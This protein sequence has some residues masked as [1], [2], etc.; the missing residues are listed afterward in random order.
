M[1]QIVAKTAPGTWI[2]P[3][4]VFSHTGSSTT[5]YVTAALDWLLSHAFESPR[6]VAAN[7]SFAINETTKETDYCPGNV[8]ADRLEALIVNGIVPVIATG[9]VG[10]VDGVSAPS[11]VEGVLAIG[12]TTD[13]YVGSRSYLNPTHC[14]DPA[15]SADQV[16]CFSNSHPTMLSVFAPGVDIGSSVPLNSQ[17]TS[18]SVLKNSGTSAAAAHVSGAVAIL[19]GNDAFGGSKSAQ[20]MISLIENNGFL[21]IDRRAA[22]IQKPRLDITRVLHV[23]E[24]LYLTPDGST[25]RPG[26]TLQLSASAYDLFSSEVTNPAVA[27]TSSNSGVARVDSK[28]LVTAVTDGTATIKGSAGTATAQVS[29]KVSSRTGGGDDPCKIDPR[30][31]TFAPR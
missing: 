19:R 12:A 31:C 24:R 9:N 17:D 10:W 7:M 25:L 23:V 5:A 29:V 2:T 20:Q 28:G 1:S 22:Q 8:L 14:N 3:L 11:C 6:I 4:Q 13:S 26:N 18:A 21:M 30:R 15:L 27:Y 16:P